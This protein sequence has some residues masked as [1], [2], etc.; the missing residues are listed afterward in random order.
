M[1]HS[2]GYY[3]YSCVLKSEK[4]LYRFNSF[5]YTFFLNN[6]V[7]RMFCFYLFDKEFIVV[8]SLVNIKYGLMLVI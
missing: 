8:Y 2:S 1:R 5:D 6:Q 3:T 7:I 4:V